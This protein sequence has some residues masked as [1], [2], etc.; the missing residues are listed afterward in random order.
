MNLLNIQP[1]AKMWKGNLENIFTVMSTPACL[2]LIPLGSS[3]LWEVLIICIPIHFTELISIPKS[4]WY[5]STPATVPFHCHRNQCDR[6][7]GNIFIFPNR[8]R[9]E[10]PI[11]AT[12]VHLQLFRWMATPAA[13]D[14]QQVGPKNILPML[15][16]ACDT[17]KKGSL[18]S[19]HFLSSLSFSSNHQQYTQ[20]TATLSSP[21]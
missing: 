5:H 9:E 18:L 16:D 19:P 2:L 14:S 12:S 11:K 13:E 15:R 4:C 1:I 20:I 10:Q 8:K 17:P 21:E 3:T 7:T 6:Q